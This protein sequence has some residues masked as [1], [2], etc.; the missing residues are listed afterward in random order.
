M[1][2][3]NVTEEPS[4]STTEILHSD[5]AIIA[6]LDL[7]EPN[8]DDAEAGTVQATRYRQPASGRQATQTLAGHYMGAR[9][10]RSLLL[11]RIIYKQSTIY[12]HLL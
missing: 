2:E 12:T 9:Q 1:G 11:L 10:H 7:F 4:S 5:D 3:T 8:S 6:F